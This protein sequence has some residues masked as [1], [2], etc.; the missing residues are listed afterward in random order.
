MSEVMLHLT[1]CCSVFAYCFLAALRE[2]RIGAPVVSEALIS[3]LRYRC[4]ETNPSEQIAF[5]RFA[6]VS[7]GTGF[8]LGP[9]ALWPE[10]GLRKLMRF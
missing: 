3:R 7:I 6:K 10:N 4:R 1:C 8:A 2:R 9:T 5:H